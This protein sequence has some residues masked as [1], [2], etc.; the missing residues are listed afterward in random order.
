LSQPSFESKCRNDSIKIPASLDSLVEVS[1][2]DAELFSP[3]GDRLKAAFVG[4]QSWCANRL[5]DGLCWG[6]AAAKPLGQYLPANATSF[7]QL[8]QRENVA[9]D[10][11]K[12]LFLWRGGYRAFKTPSALET[13]LEA[14]CVELFFFGPIMNSLSLTFIGVLLYASSVSG[15]GFGVGPSAIGWL[16]AF[17]VIYSVNAMARSRLQAHVFKEVLERIEP[18]LA[19]FYSSATVPT[20]GCIFRVE[21]S[22][23]HAVPRS[24][25]SSIRASVL[26][27][28]FSMVTSAACLR[29]LSKSV[30]HDVLNGS[31]PASAYPKR[32]ALPVYALAAKYEPMAEFSAG[33]VDELWHN[34][35]LAH[36]VSKSCVKQ[37]EVEN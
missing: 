19:Y 9:I 22:R 10:F 13:A 8:R 23:L 15:L 24:I 12:S 5:L 34:A 6:H 28:P 29:A 26:C 4:I 35:P 1:R 25:L 2:V 16:I 20:V 31:T 33:Q 3:L 11:V 37:A 17:V 30:A 27:N 36:H 21:A 32:L 18:S 14:N 7:C